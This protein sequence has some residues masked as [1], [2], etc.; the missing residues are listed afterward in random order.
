[1]HRVAKFGLW[2]GN[3]FGARRTERDGHFYDSKLESDL[4]WE[5]ECRKKAGEIKEIQRQVT[6]PLDVNGIHI[7]NYRADFV[8][9]MADGTQ[10]VMEAK[11][12]LMPEANMKLKLFTALYPDI[13]LTVIRR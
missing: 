8:V 4:G 11:G 5:L 3:K 12:I 6:F 7:T 9:T 1:M 10:E 2:K 13:K